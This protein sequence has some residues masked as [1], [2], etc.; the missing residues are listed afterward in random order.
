MTDINHT[1]IDL[2]GIV[3]L[4]DEFLD[5]Y[6]PDDDDLTLPRIW[7]WQVV[8]EYARDYGFTLIADAVDH[9]GY[10]HGEVADALGVTKQAVQQRLLRGTRALVAAPK[11]RRTIQ[12]EQLP[13]S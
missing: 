10:T 12:R 9:R 3:R 5:T 8:V 7:A 11:H 13:L 4:V 2:D 1:H 6:Y